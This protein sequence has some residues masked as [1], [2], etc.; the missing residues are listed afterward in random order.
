MHEERA[1]NTERLAGEAVEARPQ[2]QVLALDLLHQQL[3][4][5]VLLRWKMPLMNT[6]FISVITCD[7]QGGEQSLEFQGHRVFP[8]AHDT[9]EHSPRP[10]IQRM[11]QPPCRRFGFDE[12]PHFI[13]LCGVSCP[14]VGGA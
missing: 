2:R 6:R 1:G 12:T 7:I 5:R 4:Y 14:V 8:G 13:E 11:P 3:S 10:M 9:R